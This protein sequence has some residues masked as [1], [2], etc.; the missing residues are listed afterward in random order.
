V[1]RLGSNDTRA[2]NGRGLT[3]QL[4]GDIPAALAAHDEA[5]RLDPA[6]AVSLLP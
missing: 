5:I 6:G 3:L 1:I 4:L 2:Y